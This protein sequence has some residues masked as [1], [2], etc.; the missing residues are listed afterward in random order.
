[1][2]MYGDAPSWKNPIKKIKHNKMLGQR[3][4]YRSNKGDPDLK[5]IS[6]GEDLSWSISEGIRQEVYKFIGELGE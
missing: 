5:I 2:E 3:S 4:A 6:M 1:M